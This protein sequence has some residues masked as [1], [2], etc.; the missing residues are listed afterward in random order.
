MTFFTFHLSALS[1]VLLVAMLACVGAAL[2]FGL[3]PLINVI[4]YKSHEKSQEPLADNEAPHPSRKIS[5]VAYGY[6]DTDILPPFLDAVMA[7]DYDDF[8][9]IVVLDSSQ[10]KTANITEEL[11]GRYPNLYLTFIPPGSRSL[12][13]RKLALMVGIKA[14]KGEVVVL[15]ATNCCPA[16]GHWLSEVAEATFGAHKEV[17]LGI[18]VDSNECEEAAAHPFLRFA[19][20]MTTLQWLGFAIAGAPYRGDGQNLA[21]ARHLFFDNKGYA[22][23]LFLQGGEDDMFV[24]EITNSSNTSVM[25]SPD[26]FMVA[27]WGDGWRRMWHQRRDRYDFIS[28]YLRRRPFVEAGISSALQWLV[29][30]LF[31]NVI[32]FCHSTIWPILFALIP[33]AALYVGDRIIYNRAASRIKSPEEKWLVCPYMLARPVANFY[34]RL[35]SRSKRFKNYTWQRP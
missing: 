14:A 1:I 12:S 25:L 32:I 29:V 33:L 30:I 19:G 9:V 11:G 13:R 31:I 15:T 18:S 4:R 10:E 26:S 28:R 21:F 35:K 23:S 17:A 5:V 34:W 20:S 24:S 16:S 8:E 27:E 22:R 7:Q 2:L 3:R 6:P